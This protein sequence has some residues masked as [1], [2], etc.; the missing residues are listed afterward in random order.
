VTSPWL[1]AWLTL[2]TAV[3]SFSLAI[4][5]A[6][7]RLHQ[8]PSARFEDVIDGAIARLN[9]E[10][11]KDV[12][13]VAKYAEDLAGVADSM[14]RHRHRIDGAE[15]G[16]RRAERAEA[17]EAQAPTEPQTIEDVMRLAR[18]RGMIQ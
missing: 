8:T 18:A 10:R 2:A 14:K 15:G 11:S 6:V 17:E 3:A 12:L 5:I 13:A 7:W 4:A 16:K 9:A 1:L